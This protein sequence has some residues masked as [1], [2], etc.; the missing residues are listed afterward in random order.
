[1]GGG[2]WY[3]MKIAPKPLP[4]PAGAHGSATGNAA[5]A[6]GQENPPPITLDTLEKTSQTMMSLNDALKAREQ[7]VAQREERVKEREDELDAERA[8]L[9]DSHEKFKALF[10]EFQSRL[11]LVEANQAAQLQKQADLYTAMGLDQSIDLIRVMDDPAVTRLFSVMDTKP[12]GKLIAAWKNKYPEDAQ[13]ILRALDGMAQVMP[14]EKIE[15]TDDSNSTGSGAASG[16]PDNST[17]PPAPATDGTTAPAPSSDGSAAP[18]STDPAPDPN[19]TPAAPMD[20]S[21]P[22]ASPAPTQDSTPPA[23]P[24]AAPSTPPAD[25]T[26]SLTPPADPSQTPAKSQ[27]PSTSTASL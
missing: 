7:A 11:Q 17:P 2:F 23:D 22:A 14:K 4:T 13:R 21:A 26:P 12:L 24:S 27:N 8:T 1:M 3:G 19:A 20:P 6:S 25:S 10:N 5:T 9:N 18:A 15:L 16:S